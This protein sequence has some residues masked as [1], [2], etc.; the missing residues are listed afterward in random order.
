MMVDNLAESFIFWTPLV[1]SQVFDP[2]LSNLLTFYGILSYIVGSRCSRLLSNFKNQFVSYGM[3]ILFYHTD[4]DLGKYNSHQDQKRCVIC[5]E[6]VPNVKITPP[7]K[8]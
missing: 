6:S 7:K 4:I 2:A 1:F 3:T 5:T 8:Y